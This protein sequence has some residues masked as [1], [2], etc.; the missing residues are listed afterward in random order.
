MSSLHVEMSQPII[1]KHQGE[2]WAWERPQQGEHEMGF[3]LITNPASRE[4][5]CGLPSALDGR[6][7]S[8]IMDAQS[9]ED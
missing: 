4:E 2:Q 1:G 3:N 5:S 7:K 9:Q 8:P 6:D